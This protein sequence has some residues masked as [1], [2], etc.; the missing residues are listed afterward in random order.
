MKKYL[1]KIINKENLSVDESMSL[2]SMIMDGEL[3]PSQVTSI[4][5]ALRC[6]GESLNEILGFAQA[7]RNNMKKATINVPSID[8]CG[9][10]G[11]SF[12]SFNIST[13]ASFVVAGAGIH[14]AKHGNRS[15]SSKCGSA[16]VLEELGIDID[17]S[18]SKTILNIEKNK[19]GFLYAPKY[20]PAMKFAAEARNSIKIKTIFNLLGPL[21]NPANAQAQSMGIFN[22]DLTEQQA[23]VL[24]KLG[25]KR[26]MV[27]CGYDGLDEI[28]ITTKTKIS[29]FDENS[30]VRSYDFNPEDYGYKI[31]GKNSILGGSSKDNAKITIDILKG[32]KGPKRDIVILNAASGIIVSGSA[33]NFN[34]A[35]SIANH[36]IDSGKAYEVLKSISK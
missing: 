26:G 15:I 4:I 33:K 3:N 28:T 16:D 18:I 7:M 13:V 21:T 17:V 1:E 10:G 31:H 36:S 24:Q 9:T 14:V 23:K 20:H 8:M 27:F 25:V 19:L 11:D 34:E 12:G 2:M 5:V 35:I 32:E 30:D 6:K 29:H 22:K